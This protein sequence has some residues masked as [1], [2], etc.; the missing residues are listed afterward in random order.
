MAIK[1]LHIKKLQACL[2]S[3]AGV[4]LVEMVVVVAIV[5]VVSSVIIFNYSTFSTNASVKSLAQQVALSVRKAQAYATSVRNI[6]NT[7]TDTILY[8]AYGISFAVNQSGA[9]LASSKQF[10]LFADIP[11]SGSTIGD[12]KYTTNGT[13]GNPAFGSECIETFT[14][15][16]A[17]TIVQLCTNTSGTETCFSDKEVDIVFRRPS[18]DANVCLL[19]GGL[20]QVAKPAYAKVVLQSLKGGQ[21][22]ITVWTTGQIS[23]N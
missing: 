12:G 11:P 14:I 6:D 23:V 8:P 3:Q 22:T 9:T 15:T 10:V 16:S 20:C 19:V 13:C 17:D 7:S 2:R 1:D 4:T 21:K 5:A 18:P